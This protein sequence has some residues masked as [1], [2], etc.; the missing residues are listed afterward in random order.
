MFRCHNAVYTDCFVCLDKLIKFFFSRCL[1]PDFHSG[2]IK[3]SKVGLAGDR[4]PGV[5]R[6]GG[7]SSETDDCTLKYVEF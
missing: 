2:E 4:N 7:S 1:L 3:I 5:V 6:S